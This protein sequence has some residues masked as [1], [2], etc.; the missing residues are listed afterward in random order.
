MPNTFSNDRISLFNR[1]HPENPKDSVHVLRPTHQYSGKITH[2]SQSPLVGS[3]KRHIDDAIVVS[4]V[5]ERTRQAAL[6][7]FSSLTIQAAKDQNARTSDR[8]K[9]RT[10]TFL[11]TSFGTGACYC[12]AASL[13]NPLITVPVLAASTAAFILG[14][15]Q[16]NRSSQAINGI[17]LNKEALQKQKD[18]WNDPIESIIN[19]RRRAGTEGFQYVFNNNLKNSVVHP[20]EVSNLWTRDFLKLLN[21]SIDPVKVFHDNILGQASLQYAWDNTTPSPIQVGK[22]TIFAPQLHKMATLYQESAQA[23]RNFENKITKEFTDIDNRRGDRINTISLL[24]TQWLIPAERMFKLATLEAENLYKSGFNALVQQR[25]FEIAAIERAYHYVIQNPMDID[26]VNYKTRLDT[27]CR[28]AIETARREFQRHPAVITIQRAYE[29]DQRMNTLL[30]NQSKLVVDNFFDEQ[31]RQLNNEVSRAKQRVE[32]QRYSGHQLFTNLLERILH[33]R[34]D[35]SLE[36]ISISSP[37]VVREWNISNSSLQPNWNEVYG[38][39]PSFHSSFA[40]DISENAWNRF[41]GIQGLGRFASHSTS[42]WNSLFTDRSHFPWQDD[43]FS[44]KTCSQ[45]FQRPTFCQPV[46]VPPPPFRRAAQNPRPPIRPE[47]PRPP[48]SR[49]QPIPQSVPQNDNIR[50]NVG[51]AQSAR[52][53]ENT[54]PPVRQEIPVKPNVAPQPMPSTDGI[55]VRVGDAQPERRPVDPI[56]TAR[57]EHTVPNNEGARVR[58]GFGTTNR[59]TE[60]PSQ[61]GKEQE[62]STPSIAGNRVRVGYAQTERRPDMPTRDENRVRVGF[63]TTTRRSEVPSQVV[64]EEEQPT[65][66]TAG[67]R[68]RVGYANTQRR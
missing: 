7:H 46:V 36:N 26:E 18:E 34:D 63:G 60:D 10:A 17:A 41:W 35:L 30:Y 62:R 65:P 54:R 52:R 5:D 11:G 43:W 3:S 15:T 27:L 31:V 51:S 47:P 64:K 14:A 13:L 20:E 44:V 37:Q 53:E 9:A 48:L 40:N 66:V 39:L 68:V 2:S 61:V 16:W 50:V 58:V 23:F 67:N 59:R 28:N 25:D 42:S 12:L 6:E 57:E 22:T 33:P 1:H 32:Q 55:R 29:K 24:R 38:R 56:L 8:N 21:N 49:E 45:Q 19:Q 4:S